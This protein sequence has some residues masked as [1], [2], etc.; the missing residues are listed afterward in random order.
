[1]PKVRLTESGS[2]SYRST[3]D[4]LRVEQGETVEVDTDRAVYLTEHQGFEYVGGLASF[5]TAG[6]CTEILSSGDRAGEPC[7]RDLPCQFHS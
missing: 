5:D 3:R 2:D 6:T 7:G 1:M 4:G